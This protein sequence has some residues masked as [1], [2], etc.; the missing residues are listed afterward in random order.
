[1]SAKGAIAVLAAFVA[2]GIALYALR[3]THR[4]DS[5]QVRPDGT[6]A[7][8][9]I[10]TAQPPTKRPGRE[11]VPAQTSTG[12]EITESLTEQHRAPVVYD[13]VTNWVVQMSRAERLAKHLESR[14]MVAEEG[15][16]R[17]LRNGKRKLQK[18]FVYSAK[19]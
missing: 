8:S 14:R 9:P 11:P 12:A 13:G 1:M 5:A 3:N 16:C 17:M 15:A 7:S 19:E 4:I 6:S 2:V 18:G 10:L